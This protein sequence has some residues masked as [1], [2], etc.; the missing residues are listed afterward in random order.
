MIG[1]YRIA[2]TGAAA[3]LGLVAIAAPARAVTYTATYTGVV[4]DVSYAGAFTGLFGAGADGATFTAVFTWNGDD[5]IPGFQVDDP[6][7]SSQYYS[8]S[9]TGT[10]TFG[11]F[12]A[13]FQDPGVGDT[14]YG[15]GLVAQGY[16]ADLG[17]VLRQQAVL[18]EADWSNHIDDTQLS[19][20]SGLGAA[21]SWDWRTPGV[22]DL[23]GHTAGGYLGFISHDLNPLT[24]RPVT[25][26]RAEAQL[27]LTSLV[28]TAGGPVSAAPEPAAW[29][30]MI[31]GFG[32][33]GA[34]LRTRRRLPA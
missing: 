7:V 15:I 24:H 6:G 33:M 16:D 29:A 2:L 14:H 12:S 26:D 21:A 31:V 30:L 32:G 18:T 34:A 23:T 4:S 13:S 8:Y 22:Y 25:N 10:I 20:A 1:K 5:P 27:T 28:I 11:D 19:L 3:A 17:E 9:M